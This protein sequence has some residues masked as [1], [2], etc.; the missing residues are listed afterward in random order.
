LVVCRQCSASSTSTAAAASRPPS[1]RAVRGVAVS[2]IDWQSVILP[3]SLVSLERRA[4]LCCAVFYCPLFSV[5]KHGHRG[6]GDAGTQRTFIHRRSLPCTSVRHSAFCVCVFQPRPLRF[7]IAAPLCATAHP[8]FAATQCRTHE[9][10]H[11]GGQ[12]VAYRHMDCCVLSCAVVCCA[13]VLCCGNV[14]QTA[15]GDEENDSMR[16]HRY[17]MLLYE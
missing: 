12:S 9:T 6:F 11:S 10:I 15:G 16:T 1:A 13:A 5:A 14:S 7:L 4:V 2:A 17:A 8:S 3:W